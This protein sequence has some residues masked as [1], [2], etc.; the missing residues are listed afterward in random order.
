MEKTGE[1]GSTG[2]PLE[3]PLLARGELIQTADAIAKQAK[4][5]DLHLIKAFNH[6][7][8]LIVHPHPDTVN[9]F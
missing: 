3:P 4:H 7:V 1:Q 6:V 5:F 2:Q 8:N 9:P